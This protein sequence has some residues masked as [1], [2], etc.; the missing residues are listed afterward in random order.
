METTKISNFQKRNENSIRLLAS[1]KAK[2][3]NG[4]RT[5]RNFIKIGRTHA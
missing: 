4:K 2:K 3:R 1:I 5:F